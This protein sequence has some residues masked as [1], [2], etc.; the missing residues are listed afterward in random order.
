MPFKFVAKFTIIFFLKKIKKFLFLH[1]NI[2]CG[3]SLEVPQWGASNEFQQC[4]I[5]EL[6]YTTV[7]YMIVSDISVQTKMYRFNIKKETIYVYK[8]VWIVKKKWPSY[9]KCIDYYIEKWR[10]M[11][12]KTYRLYRKMTIQTKMY[13]LYRKIIIYVYKKCREY[14]AKWPI[15]VIFLYTLYTLKSHFLKSIQ[16]CLVLLWTLA[17]VLYRGCGIPIPRLNAALV[18]L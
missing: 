13:R 6:L 9:Q 2:Y 4:I 5:L 18:W 7:N 8:N 3:Y 1:R 10:F 17:K 12:T 15:M 14:I 11:F 16:I